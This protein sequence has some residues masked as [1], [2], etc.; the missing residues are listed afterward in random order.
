MRATNRLTA[1]TVR[2]A[3]EP[4]LY[5]DGGGL[6]LQVSRSHTKA[7]V[8]R[9]MRAGRARKMGLGPV[10][11]RPDDK[12]ITLADARQKAAEARSLLLDGID[13][14]TAREQRR[15]AAALTEA[16]A[17]KF[18]VAA[19]QYI[20]DNAAGWRNEKH[21][22]QWRSTLARYAYPVIGDLPVGDI[23]T[24]LVLKILRPIW[25]E[26]TETASR[27]R[28]RVEAILDWA[29]T[30]GYR[31]GE[32]PARW[33]GHLENVLPAKSKVSNVEHHRALPYPELP[34]F[35]VELRA[36][37][38]ISARA[39]EFTILTVART[40]ETIGA[41]PAEFDLINKVWTIPASRMKAKVAHRVPLPAR[42]LEIIEAVQTNQQFA[43]PGTSHDRPLSNMAMLELV[44]GMLGRGATVHGF[45]ST[46]MDWGHELT[47][48]PKEMLDIALAHKV[49]DKVE[50]AYRRGDMF[51]KRRRL[52]ADWAEYCGAGK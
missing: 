3:L 19:E 5:A 8:F 45:R 31:N 21:G 37:D 1:L 39:L 15:A 48:H 49:A 36:R 30:Q 20:D 32:N 12:R 35:M 14:I 16:K 17:I 47:S 26:K 18:K 9:F 34:G 10:S 52:M 42:A 50:A 43:F 24:G 25:N 46:F 7:W 27:V 6:Y 33:R 51:E 41:V 22:G 29:N 44:R 38:G 2:K 40:N 23:D 4:G 28:G 13:P 11:V